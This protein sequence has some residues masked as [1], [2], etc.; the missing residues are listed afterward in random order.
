VQAAKTSADN[1]YAGTTRLLLIFR[2]FGQFTH[3]T[4]RC[5]DGL[6]VTRNRARFC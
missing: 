6:P 3:Y 1:D 4:K 5:T 2:R